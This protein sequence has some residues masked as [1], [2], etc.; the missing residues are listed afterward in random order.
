MPTHGILLPEDA[1]E[2]PRVV[3]TQHGGV[4]EDE[5][6]MIVFLERL[7]RAGFE[8]TQ[9]ARH[10]EVDYQTACVDAKE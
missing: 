5:F 8:D 3:I 2:A 10:A 6:D 7:L 4:V 1:A 9:A